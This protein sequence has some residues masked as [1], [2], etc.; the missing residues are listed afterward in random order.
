MSEKENVAV[1]E[2]EFPLYVY[3]EGNN[4]TALEFF[5]AHKGV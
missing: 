1:N 5:G 3:H 4:F 2:Y